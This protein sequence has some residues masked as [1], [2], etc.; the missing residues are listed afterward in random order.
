MQS[1]R[2]NED[3]CDFTESLVEFCLDN[4]TASVAVGIG[5]KFFE[6]RTNEDLFKQFFNA[7]TC[8][9][10]HSYDGGFSAPFFGGYAVFGKLRKHSVGICA[11]SVHLVE[12][13]DNRYVRLFCVADCFERLWHDA[14]VGSNDQNRNIRNLRTASTH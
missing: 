9:C 12:S 14:V 5:T 11:R 7:H 1:T 13:D 6:F 8:L 3:C 2:L 10:R 4:R